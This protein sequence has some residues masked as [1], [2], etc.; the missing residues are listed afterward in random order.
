MRRTFKICLL[1]ISPDL[2]IAGHAEAG[3]HGS[4]TIQP[5]AVD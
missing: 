3:M 5:S 2:A 1:M 4:I